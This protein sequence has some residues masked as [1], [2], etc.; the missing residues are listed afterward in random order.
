MTGARLDPSLECRWRWMY[1]LLPHL[2]IE[3]PLPIVVRRGGGHRE[4][5][6]DGG[7]YVEEG[8]WLYRVRWQERWCG[9]VGREVVRHMLEGGGCVKWMEAH[10]EKK[11]K[12]G[13][14]E[15]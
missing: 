2:T 9:S 12:I 1:L 4:E 10:R 11:I 3:A 15:E 5:L 13:E 6:H 8:S 14:V 7:R